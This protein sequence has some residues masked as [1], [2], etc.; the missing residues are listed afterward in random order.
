MVP[1]RTIL[2]PVDFSDCSAGAFHLACSLAELHR[3][4]LVV[5]H[6]VDVE[7]GK[8]SFGGVMVEVRPSDY[9]ERMLEA[10]KRL[11][12]PYPTVPIEHIVV[13]GRPAEEILRLAREMRCDLIVMGTHGLTGFRRLLLGSVAEEVLRQAPCPVVT[14]R[15]APNPAVHV[16]AS[17]SSA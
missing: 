14:V 9:P 8:H 10:L 12:P 1:F 5:A 7:Y 2:C 6:V 17:R 3:A 16:A 13:K 15:T 11:D 4:R